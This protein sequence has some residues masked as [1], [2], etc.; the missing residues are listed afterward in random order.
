M[1][2][3]LFVGEGRIDALP[4]DARGFAYGDGLFETMRVQQR[5]EGRP[6][7]MHEVT[8]HVDV[9]PRGC[10]E[11]SMPAGEVGQLDRGLRVARCHR[12][13]RPNPGGIRDAAA[14]RVLHRAHDHRG[15]AVAGRTNVE[16]PER[17]RHS[18]SQAGPTAE[19]DHPL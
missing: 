9:V 12:R 13:D 6:L 1:K 19:H 11:S 7:E 16:Q 15:G 4:G 17:I 10:A 5:R 18:G 2:E 3:R 8:W 14:L